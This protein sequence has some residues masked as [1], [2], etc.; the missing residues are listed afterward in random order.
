MF[1][2]I[3]PRLA[4]LHETAHNQN[5][6]EWPHKV[7]WVTIDRQIIDSPLAAKMQTNSSFISI[8]Q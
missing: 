7:T 6:E 3:P 4:L 8:F 1:T 2:P 5:M